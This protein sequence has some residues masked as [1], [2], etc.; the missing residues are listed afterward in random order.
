VAALSQIIP[1]ERHN[2]YQGQVAWE[3]LDRGWVD[4]V[5][6]MAYGPNTQWLNDRMQLL[7]DATQQESSRSRLFPGIVTHDLHNQSDLWSYLIV[8]Q[9]EA[10]MRGQWTGQPLDPPAKGMALF[11]EHRLSD[12]AVELLGQGP[13]K[14]PAVPFWGE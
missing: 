4:A 9:V 10:T 14:E 2:S 7:R 6:V 5:F 1:E 13:F 11:L 3:W 8:E 12:E